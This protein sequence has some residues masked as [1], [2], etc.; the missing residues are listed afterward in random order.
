MDRR[1]S[2][3]K[4]QESR[5]PRRRR[6]WSKRLFDMLASAWR[7]GLLAVPALSWANLGQN[8]NDCL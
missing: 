8:I 1:S 2:L 4:R 5:Y 6:A 7:I 3:T